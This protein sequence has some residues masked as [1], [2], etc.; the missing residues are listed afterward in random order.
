MKAYREVHDF[1]F[2]NGKPNMKLWFDKNDQVDRQI[3]EKFEPWL[4][5]YPDADFESWKQTPEGLVSLVIMLDQF[6]RNAFRGTP[7]MFEYDADARDVAQEGLELGWQDQ[8][9]IHKA[10]FML[11][12]LEHSE[13]VT[14]QKECVRLFKDLFARASADEI[15]LAEGV[16]QYAERHLAIIDRFGRFPHRNAVLGRTSTPEE[17]EFLKQPGSGF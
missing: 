11:L 10:M 16:L 8:L 4:N 5:Q 17:I 12:P 9:P 7:R 1:W 14:D 6:P 2:T 13:D 15:E 3:R